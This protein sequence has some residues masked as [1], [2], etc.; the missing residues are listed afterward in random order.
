[1]SEDKK[2]TYDDL[3]HAIT[4]LKAYRDPEPNW[5]GNPGDT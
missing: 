4:E 1:M 5:F 3:A 2:L